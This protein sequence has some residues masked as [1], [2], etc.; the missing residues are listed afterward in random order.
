MRTILLTL[1]MMI[2]LAMPVGAEHCVTWSTHAP[3]VDTKIASEAA[4]LD[5]Y[6]VADDC[7]PLI[8]CPMEPIF[9]LWIYE[10][11]NGIEGLQRGDE[12][13]DDTCHGMIDGDTIVF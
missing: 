8:A 13:Y 11:S 12:V 6:Y 1:A 10:E 9:S 2:A 5:R 7:F 4:G 3:E